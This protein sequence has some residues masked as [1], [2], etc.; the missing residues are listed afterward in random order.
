MKSKKIITVVLTCVISLIISLDFIGTA[1]KVNN[2]S[3]NNSIMIIENI[4]YTNNFENTKKV[5]TTKLAKDE[6]RI[7]N[8][9]TV[10][11]RSGKREP[12][13][14]LPEEVKNVESLTKVASTE[15]AD[16]VEEKAQEP[17]PEVIQP[18]PTFEGIEL[19]YSARY[20][21]SSSRLSKSKGV[22]YYNGHKETYYSQRV[23][24][25]KGL[26]A[27]NNNGR[28]V[29]NDGTVR[30]GDGY[31]AVACNYLPK[32]SK[33]MTSLGPGKVYDTGGMTGKWIDIYVNW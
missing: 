2:I 4:P 22:T 33:I 6:R 19:Q 3:K 9:K 7:I 28:H 14:I 13:V 5:S 10:T 32:G 27:L 15:S 18:K 29:A 12:L 26:K 31:I 20:N 1:K 17:A 23:L 8:S 21:V 16:I 25:G 24:S 11:S 30:D